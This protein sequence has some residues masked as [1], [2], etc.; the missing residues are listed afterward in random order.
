MTLRVKL[1]I[2]PHGIEEETREI[3]RIE[4][5]NMGPVS[6]TIYEQGICDY[7]VRECDKNSTLRER[8]VIHKRSHGALT[9]VYTALKAILEKH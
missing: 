6:G 9:L 2:V 5:S 1:E 8:M 3:G 7:R 4:I